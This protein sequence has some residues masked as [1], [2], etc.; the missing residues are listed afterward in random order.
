[1]STMETLT[2]INSRRALVQRHPAALLIAICL[3]LSGCASLLPDPSSKVRQLA[4]ERWQ[5]LLAGQYERAYEM[6][7]P[8]YRKAKSLDY[9]RLNI[10][11]VPVKWKSA[12]VLRADCEEKRCKVGIRLVSELRI[13]GRYRGDLETSL[14]ETWVLEDGHWWMLETR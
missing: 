10:Q 14:E 7:A 12:Q 4:T 2:P 6:A 9:Y 5:A 3:T 8:A 13:P 11:G 1:M